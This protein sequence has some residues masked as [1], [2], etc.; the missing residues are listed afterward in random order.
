MT[1]VSGNS[2]QTLSPI[3]ERNS[4]RKYV[5]GVLQHLDARFHAPL[6]FFREMVLSLRLFPSRP[7]VEI[8]DEE[9]A[10]CFW[11]PLGEGPFLVGLV[12]LIFEGFRDT[13]SVD[14]KW[15]FHTVFP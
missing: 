12:P 2:W 5:C 4:Y 3:L 11:K 8:S 15:L 13:A 7:V 6:H 14:A 9:D 1:G 10:S